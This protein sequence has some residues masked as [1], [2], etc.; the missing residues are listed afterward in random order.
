MRMNIF[1]LFVCIF[2]VR[3][4]T[5]FA[6]GLTW[7]I[8]CPAKNVRQAVVRQKDKTPLYFD[9]NKKR[10]V[11]LLYLLKASTVPKLL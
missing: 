11:Y 4:Q 7:T 3:G 2:F 5:N 9:R 10:N 6:R 8:N 1:F